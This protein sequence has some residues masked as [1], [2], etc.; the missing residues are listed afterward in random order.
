MVNQ[1]DKKIL[2]I[3]E[4]FSAAAE[5]NGIQSVVRRIE[6]SLADGVDSDVEIFLLLNQSGNI[7][8][9]NV[10]NWDTTVTASNTVTDQRISRGRG[11]AASRIT[12]RM[13]VDGSFLVIGRDMSDI[14]SVRSL[15]VQ[16]TIWGGVLAVILA[17]I[18][19]FTL[20][21][22]IERKVFSIRAV[23]QEIEVVA[24]ISP[25]IKTNSID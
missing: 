14:N 24:S 25:E 17:V 7:I 21:H 15:L 22:Q 3:A 4:N 23:A 2:E 6:T 20:R 13:L 11:M 9:G 10:S 18:A 8:A 19:M 12:T 1:V 5:R 16:A